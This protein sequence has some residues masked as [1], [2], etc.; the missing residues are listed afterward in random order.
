MLRIGRGDLAGLLMGRGALTTAS[1]V[2]HLHFASRVRL[3]S[4]VSGLLPWRV[5]VG[6]DLR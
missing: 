1:L 2:E 3:N 6:R 4:E 5:R